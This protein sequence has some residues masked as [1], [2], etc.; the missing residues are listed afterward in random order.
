MI[1]IAGAAVAAAWAFLA[2]WVGPA[3]AWAVPLVARARGAFGGLGAVLASLAGLAI[4]AA[5]VWSV[6]ALTGSSKI[7]VKEARTQCDNAITSATLAA[8]ERAL[9]AREQALAERE[10]RVVRDELEIAARERELTEARH[11]TRTNDGVIAI[12]ADDEWLRRRRGRR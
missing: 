11:A 9:G 2:P 5:T 3:L 1:A 6:W 4:L 10:A 12:G 7:T 8:R